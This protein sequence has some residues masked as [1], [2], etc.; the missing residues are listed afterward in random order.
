MSHTLEILLSWKNQRT[1]GTCRQLLVQSRPEGIHEARTIEGWYFSTA[2]CWS[3]TM[4]STI[5]LVG[6]TISTGTT[7]VGTFP[8]VFNQEASCPVP[9]PRSS[10]GLPLLSGGKEPS[11]SLRCLPRDSTI[12]WVGSRYKLCLAAKRPN[13]DQTRLAKGKE[14]LIYLVKDASLASSMWNSS[15]IDKWVSG[16]RSWLFSSMRVRFLMNGSASFRLFL[17]CL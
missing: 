9:P 14:S 13:L 2:S 15:S 7:C 16:E 10:M 8:I 1:E 3:I 6:G 17:R 11:V 5:G 12:S 4:T